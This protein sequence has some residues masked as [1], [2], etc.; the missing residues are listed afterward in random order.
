MK[1][2]IIIMVAAIVVVGGISFYGGMKYGEN[3]ALGG[4]AAF[5]QNLSPEQRQQALQRFGA[6]GGAL[7]GR[8]SGAGG[9]VGAGFVNGEIISQDDKSITVKMRDGG[10]RIIFYS[11]SKSIGKTIEGTASDL[12]VGKQITANGTA[13][14]DGSVAAQSIQILPARPAAPAATGATNP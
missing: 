13:N 3:R 10:S 1:K 5:M 8:R 4:R 12:E 14:S 9:L 11:D 6:N 7:G 2:N